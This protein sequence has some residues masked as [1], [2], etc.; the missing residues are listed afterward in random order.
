MSWIRKLF[1]AKEPAQ[2]SIRSAPCRFCGATGACAKCSGV[3]TLDG[4]TCE[5]CQGNGK[6]EGC[7]G[8]GSEQWLRASIGEVVVNRALRKAIRER[9]ERDGYK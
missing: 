9:M 3:G 7:E 8:S 5:S 4:R 2:P 1:A 6:C